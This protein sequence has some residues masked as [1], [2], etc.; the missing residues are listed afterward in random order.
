MAYISDDQI[1]DY[2]NDFFAKYD[3]NRKLQDMALANGLDIKN[4]VRLTDDQRE[5]LAVAQVA[6]MLA[7][8]EDDPRYAILSKTGLEHR[9]LRTELINRY[10]DEAIQLINKRAMNIEN[11]PNI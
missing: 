2:L 1:L 4:S 10:K 9:S 5:A 7:K 11:S 8:R 6:L 3:Q